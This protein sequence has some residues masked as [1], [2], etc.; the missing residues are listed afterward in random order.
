MRNACI[1]RGDQEIKMASDSFDFISK[2]TNTRA[3][4]FDI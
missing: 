1:H 4:L 3:I 2:T